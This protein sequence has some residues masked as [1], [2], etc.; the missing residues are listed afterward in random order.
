M[1]DIKVTVWCLAYNH[2]KYIRSAL[3]GFVMQKTNFAYE[4]LVHDD[5]STDR[6][7]EIIREYE[8]K[9]P[10][11]IKPIYEKENQYRSGKNYAT[12]FLLPNAK[13]KYIA[14]CEGDDYWTDENKLQRAYDVL[15]AHE[16]VYMCV[17]KVKCTNED[18]TPNSEVHPPKKAKL[19]GDT[20]LTPE[21]MAALVWEKVGYVFQTSSFVIRKEVLQTRVVHELFGKIT[22]DER[23]IRSAMSLGCVYYIDRVMSCRR[24]WTIG[25]YNSRQREKTNEERM[26]QQLRTLDAELLYDEMMEGRFHKYIIPSAYRML[27]S[28][29]RFTDPQTIRKIDIQYRNEHRFSLFTSKKTFIAHVLFTFSPAFYK[30]LIMKRT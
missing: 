21:E 12:S 29:I 7:A 30:Y 10:D 28:D 19:N 6:T 9:Y 4:V 24:L 2:E 25:N 3:D 17:H 8:E 15:E 14:Y 20:L 23:I 27:L 26:V 5:A 1:N 16:N 22:G 18:D 11:I 13:G